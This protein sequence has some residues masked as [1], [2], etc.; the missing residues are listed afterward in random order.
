[1]LET[2]IPG[3][4]LPITSALDELPQVSSSL[5]PSTPLP[6]S[7]P[8]APCSDATPF[9]MLP[10][11]LRAAAT[12]NGGRTEL[13]GAKIES[14]TEVGCL[15]GSFRDV[16]HSIGIQITAVRLN[17]RTPGSELWT[18]LPISG[19]PIP[20]SNIS[21]DRSLPRSL[22]KLR[23]LLHTFC[24]CMLVAGY[25]VTD[26]DAVQC[27]PARPGISKQWKMEVSIGPL[28]QSSQLQPT[29][30]APQ[31]SDQWSFHALIMGHL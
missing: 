31:P 10:A 1:M 9:S 8:T 21:I 16:A 28:P 27:D 5:G 29:V 4:T 7:T 14:M 17:L 20:R 15:L 23:P 24:D 2:P 12:A 6:T 11:D 25:V 3:S 18:D 26:V 19:R 13:N 30:S 22:A